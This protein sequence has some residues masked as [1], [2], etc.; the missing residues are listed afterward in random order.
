MSVV[1][2]FMCPRCHIVLCPSY[3]YSIVSRGLHTCAF[4]KDY[5]Q[6]KLLR[7]VSMYAHKVW[8]FI[9]HTL[10]CIHSPTLPTPTHPHIR[11]WVQLFAVLFIL[12]VSVAGCIYAG[13][14]STL[15]DKAK[16]A[17]I[18]C[19]AVFNAILLK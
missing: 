11:H 3:P 18:C 6:S 16:I 12:G 10:T 4:L 8:R 2:G 15:G 5:R 19:V 17:T 7:C 9:T 14:Y 1:F 13:G